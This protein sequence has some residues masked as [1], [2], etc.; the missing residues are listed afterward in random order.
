MLAPA[1]YTRLA[2]DRATGAYLDLVQLYTALQSAAPGAGVALPDYADEIMAALQAAAA[3]Q[4][5]DPVPHLELARIYRERADQQAALRLNYMVLAAQELSAALPLVSDQQAVADELRALYYDAA[6]IASRAGAP[7][8]ALTY[9]GKAAAVPGAEGDTLAQMETLSLRWAVDL[10]EQGMVDQALLQLAG[11]LAS[12]T[13]DA[14]LRYAPPFVSARTEVEQTPASRHVRYRL[15]LYAPSAARSVARLQ[16]LTSGV[17]AA[18]ACTTSLEYTASA[19][20]VEITAALRS[21]AD[22]SPVATAIAAALAQDLDPLGALLAAPWQADLQ[23][24]ESTP[25]LWRD[26]L[27]YAE[28]VD[29][30]PLQAVWDSQAEYVRWRAVELQADPAEGETAQLER[31]LALI[32]LRDQ[33]FIWRQLPASTYWVYRVNL[34]T[35]ARQSSWLVSWGQ[36]RLLTD[37]TTTYHWPAIALAFLGGC[38]LFLLLLRMAARTPR[39]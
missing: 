33:Q 38:V 5:A 6:T 34:P 39:P 15:E 10:A 19:A 26:Q 18:C 8:T 7:A 27:R 23:T 30:T 12:Q 1:T 36:A 11:R 9:L 32:A 14:V 17:Q 21:P 35:A 29:T 3:A 22:W 37:E 16:V 2:H 20:Q 31:R 4:P 13:E 28:Q 25:G 24:Y